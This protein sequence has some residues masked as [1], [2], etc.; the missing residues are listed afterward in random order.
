MYR[1][2]D[3]AFDRSAFD[4]VSKHSTDGSTL[5]LRDFAAAITDANADLRAQCQ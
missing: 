4:R 5:T 1:R 3:G 2:S